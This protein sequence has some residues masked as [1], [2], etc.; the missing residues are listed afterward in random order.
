MTAKFKKMNERHRTQMTFD[1]ATTTLKIKEKEINM[2]DW[3]NE[4][5]TDT[6]I[7]EVLEKYGCID[8]IKR[9]DEEL[10]ADVT[11]IQALDGMRGIVEHKAKAENMFNMLPLEVRKEFS[12]DLNKFTK[13]AP[14]YLKK[15]N[16]K[17]K[18]KEPKTEEKS[19]VTKNVEE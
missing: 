10:F 3:I 18:A 1:R 12:N 14:E 16:E 7:Y 11:A 9:T 8:K 5:R 2:A 6:E 17:I 13:E 19:E 15:L 4:G